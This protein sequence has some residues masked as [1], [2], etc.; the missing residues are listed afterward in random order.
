MKIL[1]NPSAGQLARI[2]SKTVPRWF[3]APILQADPTSNFSHSLTHLASNFSPWTVGQSALVFNIGKLEACLAMLPVGRMRICSLYQ[4]VPLEHQ[5]PFKRFIY[6]RILEKSRVLATYS[7]IS[8]AYLKNLFPQKPVVWL[9]HFT[10]TEFFQ[11][12]G[13]R[14][15]TER[16]MLA[17]GDHKRHE[18]VIIKLA[19]ALRVTIIRVSGDSRVAQYHA[20]H[21]SPFVKMLQGIN[22]D[23]L[24]QFYNDA[25]M[26]LNV[27]DD[28][29]WPVGITTFC[30]ALAMNK[31]V[32]TS[33]RHSCSGYS[34]EDGSRPYITVDSTQD[35]ECWLAAIQQ[36]RAIIDSGW[37]TG[38]SPRDMAVNFCSFEA[39][40]KG[41]QHIIKLLK[42]GD[43]RA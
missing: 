13:I 1:M 29:L 18:D 28:R 2:K 32:I 33:G 35:V 26:V 9:G 5:R 16:F 38:R 31:L 20:A 19:Q 3:A 39:A 25:E 42:N 12:V 24:R 37:K 30:E 15:S 43:Y 6:G 7:R 17:V 41:W 34:F 4:W 36:A 14:S 11:P 27:V 10:D 23:Q 8:E 40:T 21:A 22:F